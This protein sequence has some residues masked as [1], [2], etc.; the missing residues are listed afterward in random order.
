MKNYKQKE[1]I[2]EILALMVATKHCLGTTIKDA[3]KSKRFPIQRLSGSSIKLAEEKAQ[4][5]QEQVQDQTS[6][7]SID[8][9]AVRKGHS[10][11]TVITNLAVGNVLGM[12]KD[13]T[14]EAVSTFV[15]NEKGLS[16]ESIQI[17]VIEMREPFFKVVTVQFP[18]ATVVIDKYKQLG[19]WYERLYGMGSTFNDE[20]LHIRIREN[21][22]GNS[23]LVVLPHLS[24]HR[25]DL[26]K[27]VLEYL[28]LLYKK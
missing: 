3:V 1:N 24:L 21:V 14:T 8:K 12:T 28:L 11:E 10:Y 22:F 7:I 27:S 15:Q 25:L 6:V 13:R 5:Q 2:C 4:K 18:K 9:V 19:K 16:P 17:V 26:K 20:C 23:S